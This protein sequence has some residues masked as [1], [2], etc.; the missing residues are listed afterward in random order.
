MHYIFL[1]ILVIIFWITAMGMPNKHKDT[2]D[3]MQTKNTQELTS[4]TKE[5]IDVLKML[6]EGINDHEKRIDALEDKIKCLKKT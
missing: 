3:T 4:T 2:I 1:V 6:Y 5:I